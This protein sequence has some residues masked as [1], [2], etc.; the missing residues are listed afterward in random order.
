MLKISNLLYHT[1]QIRDL[2]TIAMRDANLSVDTLMQRAGAAAFRELQRRWPLAKNIIVVCGK[3]NNGGDGYVVA[4]CAAAANLKVKIL[5]LIPLE[6]LAGAAKNAAAACLADRIPIEPF[7]PEL[8]THADVIVDALLGTGIIGEVHT[9]FYAAIMAIN[10]AA[11]PVLAIDL[12]SGLDANFGNVWGISVKAQLT[13]TFLGNKMGLFAGEGPDYCGEVL[14]DDLDIPEN[15]YRQITPVAQL[16]QLSA[17]QSQLPQRQRTANKGDFGHV[18]VVGGNYGMGGAVRMAAEAAARVGAGITTLATRSE[19]I[20]AINAARPEI[21]CHGIKFGWQLRQLLQQATVVIVGP[22]LGQ[23]RWSKRLLAEVLATNK[24]LVV[25][26]DALNLL[27]H[28]PIQ[29]ANWILTP[30]PGEA[31]RLLNMSVKNIQADRVA[32]VHAL[33]SKFGGVAVLKGAGSLVASDNALAGLCAAGN[34]GMASGGMGDVLSGIIG[35]LLAQ[36]LTLSN[37]AQ[38]GVLVHAMAGD[39]AAKN[40]GMRGLLALDLLPWVQKLVD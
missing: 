28:N 25:D 8:L 9:K 35:G 36:G 10:Q 20:S 16:L 14:C 30:H 3:G 23:T 1:E 24:P 32:A 27:A 2:E 33:Q 18:L 17:L 39:A 12:P 21:M 7:A 4:R 38:L 37:A 34:P 31:A 13:V 5:N 11:I 15:V 26:A 19:H 29:R 40:L 6:Q 22:G